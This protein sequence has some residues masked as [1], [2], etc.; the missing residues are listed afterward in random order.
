MTFQLATDIATPRL[1]RRT[2]FPELELPDSK[3]V[4]ARGRDLA[5]TV[6]VGTSSFLDEMNVSDEAEYKRICAAKS[7]IMVHSQI[8]Y[9]DPEK[10]KRAYREIWQRAG[11]RHARVD[12]YGICLDWSMGFRRADRKDAQK[13]YRAHSGLRRCICGA[14]LP[15]AGRSTFW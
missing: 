15:G 6:K 13:G 8:G 7:E 14:Y 10:T 5:S 12:R 4:L 11:E 1:D 9:R 2:V 3:M